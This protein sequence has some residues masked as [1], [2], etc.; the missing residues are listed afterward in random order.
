MAL[1][2][3]RRKDRAINDETWIKAFLERAPFGV[4]ATEHV[5][6]PYINTNLFVYDDSTHAIY[7]HTAKE[8]RTATNVRLNERVCFTVIEMGRLLPADE[9][10]EFS[11]EY[12]S[13]VV[14]GRAQI[15]DSEVEKESGLQ[16]ILD[17]Y[18]SH[19]KSGEDYASINPSELKITA[20]YKL[21]VDVWS[22]KKKQV[23]PDFPGAF[24]YQEPSE[25]KK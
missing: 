1:G 21:E 12:A 6:Q 5:G 2:Q 13:V 8:G 24:W 10:I 22:G 19:L 23:Q 14:F 20:V 16:L 7:L 25:F 18:F 17:K 9:A 3:I 4:W 15:L 11:L